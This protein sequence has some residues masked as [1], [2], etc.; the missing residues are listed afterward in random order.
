MPEQPLLPPVQSQPTVSEHKA[1]GANRST[2]V[3]GKLKV[4]P[5]QPEPILDISPRERRTGPPK[6]YEEVNS[7][8]SEDGDDENGDEEPE[9]IEVRLFVRVWTFALT[10][11]RFTINY[12]LFPMVLRVGML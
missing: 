3:A 9:D 1:R 4:L 6:P 7:G 11:C 10:T 12:L 2:K 8:D 5:E